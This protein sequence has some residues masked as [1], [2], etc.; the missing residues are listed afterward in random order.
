MQKQKGKQ[1]QKI[2]AHFKVLW[3]LLGCSLYLEAEGHKTRSP[4]RRGD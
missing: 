2:M 1:R 3:K 4:G